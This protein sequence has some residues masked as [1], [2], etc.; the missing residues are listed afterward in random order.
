M[1][2]RSLVRPEG[3]PYLHY[4]YKQHSLKGEDVVFVYDSLQMLCPQPSLMAKWDLFCVC[5]GHGGPEAANFTR[6][7]LPGLIAPGLPKG[8]PPEIESEEGQLWLQTIRTAIND[9]FVQLDLDF[10]QEK[11]LP[12]VGC[13]AT[14][15]LTCGWTLTVANVGDSEGLLDIGSKEPIQVTTSH[16]I[17]TNKD[18]QTRLERCG[19][20]V[21]PLSEELFRPARSHEQGIGPLRVWPC[22]LAV[23]RAIGDHDCGQEVL[24]SPATIQIKVPFAGARLIMASDGLWDHLTAERVMRRSRKHQIHEAPSQLILK[25]RKESEFGLTDDTSVLIVDILPTPRSDFKDVS[26]KLRGPRNVISKWGQKLA[27]PSKRNFPRILLN[28][29]DMAPIESDPYPSLPLLLT[30]SS[31]DIRVKEQTG[32]SVTRCLTFAEGDADKALMDSDSQELLESINVD[33]VDHE[34]ASSLRRYHSSS[35]EIQY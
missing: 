22:G 25:A 28:N 15:A 1:S 5:D 9:A 23:S 7:N 3:C 21:R 14:V 13:T 35:L 11:S 32:S 6:I 4:S 17:D 10:R 31:K 12:T 2:T 26:R 30:T 20:E 19:K 16:K 8:P 29:E 24:A 34:A 33:E 27:K 18:E